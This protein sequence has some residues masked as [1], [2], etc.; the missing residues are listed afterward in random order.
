MKLIRIVGVT[1]L[2]AAA[3][4]I[5]VIGPTSGS[6]AGQVTSWETGVVF[7]AIGAVSFIV[8]GVL[9]EVHEARSSL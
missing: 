2:I 6:G 7:A 4:L 1:S 8:I 3:L 9:R 5:S